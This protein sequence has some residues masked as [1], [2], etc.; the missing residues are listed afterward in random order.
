MAENSKNKVKKNKKSFCLRF[1]TRG[2]ARL[3]PKVKN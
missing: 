1:G 2:A 3:V